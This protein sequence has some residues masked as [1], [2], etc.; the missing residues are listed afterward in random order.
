[1]ITLHALAC[2]EAAVCEAPL[3]ALLSDD[4]RARLARLRRPEDRLRSLT[5]RAAARLILGRC[6][7]AAPETL[8]F[9]DGPHGKPALNAAEHRAIHFN[10]AHSGE[11]VLLA[12]APSPVGVDIEHCTPGAADP[13]LAACFTEREQAHIHSRRD[14]IAQW[15]AKEAVLK[16]C[17]CGLTVDPASFEVLHDGTHWA[18]VAGPS[19]PPALAGFRVTR[20]CVKDDYCGALATA[21]PA[22]SWRLIHENMEILLTEQA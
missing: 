12:I 1:M 13:L 15:T 7:G 22:A 5:G 20:F 14:G 9:H 19:S 21:D 10:L 4:E 6:L 17:G 16:A 2:H 8:Q 11:W 3:L 18:T